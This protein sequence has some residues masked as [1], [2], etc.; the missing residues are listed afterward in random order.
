MQQGVPQQGVSSQDSVVQSISSESGLSRVGQRARKPFWQ[1]S[2]QGSHWQ[3]LV[4]QDALKL[5]G[6]SMVQPEEAQCLDSC[7][8]QSEIRVSESLGES[9]S[10]PSHRIPTSR[11]D[12][13][14]MFLYSLP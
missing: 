5:S 9:P 10:H 12:A 3:Y 2:S 11:H 7:G 4:P 1:E 6:H 14:F 13:L 8:Q